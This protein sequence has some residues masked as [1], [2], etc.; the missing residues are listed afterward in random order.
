MIKFLNRTGESGYYHSDASGEWL[1][2]SGIPLPDCQGFGVQYA[3]GTIED[4]DKIGLSVQ[5]DSTLWAVWV[6][7]VSYTH[8]DVYKRQC[9]VCMLLSVSK[10][11]EDYFH[12]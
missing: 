7:P 11:S 8:L 6:R 5:S 4:G 1:E 2:L 12:R 10:V 3:E 9:C